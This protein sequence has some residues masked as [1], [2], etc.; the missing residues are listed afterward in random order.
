[1]KSYGAG[2]SQ[3]RFLKKERHLCKQIEW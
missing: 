2:N 1:M 3:L